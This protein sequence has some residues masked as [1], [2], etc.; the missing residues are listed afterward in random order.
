LSFFKAKFHKSLL[1]PLSAVRLY[2]FFRQHLAARNWIVALSLGITTVLMMVNDLD[3]FGSA[4]DSSQQPL[5]RRFAAA[6]F[7]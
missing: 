6:V 7:A 5:S 1:S 4:A 2:E 3:Q